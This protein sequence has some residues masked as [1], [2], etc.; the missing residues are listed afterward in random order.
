MCSKN[1]HYKRKNGESFVIDFTQCVNTTEVSV[2]QQNNLQDTPR[3]MHEKAADNSNLQDAFIKYKD[4][5][6][7]SDLNSM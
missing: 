2:V 1:D 7:V 6:E 3:T 4:K 5:I